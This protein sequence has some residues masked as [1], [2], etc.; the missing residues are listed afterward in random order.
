MIQ[1][2]QYKGYQIRSNG[3]DAYIYFNGEPVG[4][5]TSDHNKGNA[6]EKA[7]DKIDSGRYNKK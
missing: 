6:I 4:G 3:I 7:K 5:A 1:E 2:I